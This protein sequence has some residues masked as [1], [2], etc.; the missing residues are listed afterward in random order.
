M[1]VICYKNS[2]PGGWDSRL[3]AAR[4]EAGLCQSTYWA[5]VIQKIDHARPIF[6]EVF[7][8]KNHKA[9]LSLMLFDKIPWDRGKMCGNIGLKQILL[10]RYGGWLEWLDG[11][12]IYSSEEAEIKEAI[13]ALLEW[14]DLRAKKRKIK[15]ISSGEFT[16]LSKW[17][18]D[19]EIVKLLLYYGYKANHWATYLVDLNLKED[20]LWARISHASRQ[21]I[22]KAQ[23]LGVRI[24]DI[25]CFEEL[26]AVYFPSYQ[27]ARAAAGL[28]VDPLPIWQIAWE[29]DKE[30]Y[31]RYYV[32]ESGQGEV[33]ATLGMYI[34]NGV[35]TE[36]AA[37][38]SPRALQEKI[39]AQ[40]LLHWEMFLRARNLGCHTFDLAGVNPFPCDAK[41]KGIRRFKEKW[42]GR[43]IEFNQFKKA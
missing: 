21:N 14:I 37:S 24:R 28:K 17:G 2:P 18:S 30:R 5:R 23:N 35:A 38:L 6:L 27:S 42:Q 4:Q 13:E 16:H 12:V 39:P 11:P 8:Q 19:G 9:V 25:S 33:L 36:F 22:K 34:F 26:K 7:N 3:Y 15:S 1:R 32:A 20:E 41:E 29:E 10:D 40:D 43:Y 31:Y